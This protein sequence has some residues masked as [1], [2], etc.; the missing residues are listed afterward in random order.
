MTDAL[1]PKLAVSAGVWRQGR[2]LLIRRAHE[3]LAGLWTFP[4]GHVEPGERVAAAVLREVMEETGLSV[5]LRGDP[6]VHEI[7]RR[8]PDGRLTGHHVLLVHAAVA[9]GAADPVAASDAAEARFVD[10][11]VLG[12][13]ATTDRLDHFVAETARRAGAR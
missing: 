13:F 10:P 8:D 6:L 3:P 4:G 2:V 1:L 11:A 5:A 7:I 9:L 12:D